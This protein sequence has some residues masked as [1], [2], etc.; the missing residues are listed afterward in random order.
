VSSRAVE[1]E[2][3]RAERIERERLAQLAARRRRSLRRVGLAAAVVGAV[4]AATAVALIPS[5]GNKQRVTGRALT[6]SQNP[7]GQH[8]RG[9]DARRK[10]AGVPTMMDTMGNQAHFHPL[11][12]LFIDGKRVQV[13]A[14]IGI[15]PSKDPM[16]MADLHTHDT[17]G[18]IHVEGMPSATLRQLFEV[19][20][21][22]LSPKRL[23][24]YRATGAKAL[25]MWV[26]RKPSRAFG[27]LQLADGQRIVLSY[28]KRPPGV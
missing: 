10:A 1:K 18:T 28:G 20:G 16:Q 23:G 13:P 24:P 6:A 12:A 4:A 2:R 14:N 25:R 21:V 9:L 3:L 11:L 7:F 8:Y 19:W 26:D 17:S 5:S 15:D 27:S 22:P